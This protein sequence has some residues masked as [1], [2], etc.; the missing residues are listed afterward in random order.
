MEAAA[1]VATLHWGLIQALWE[2]P[3][4]FHSATAV[5]PAGLAPADACKLNNSGL[6]TQPRPALKQA[7]R[8]WPLRTGKMGGYYQCLSLAKLLAI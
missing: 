2:V 8:H 4:P 5:T 6:P 7:P 3:E 1:R